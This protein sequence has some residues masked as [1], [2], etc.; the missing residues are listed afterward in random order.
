MNYPDEKLEK[1]VAR[2]I[3]DVAG[4]Q[5]DNGYL[6]TYFT[7][8]KEERFSDLPL[9]HE[10]YCAGHL[11]EAAVAHHLATGKTSLL[12]VATRFA[13]LIC[14][15]FGPDKRQ[16]APGHEEIELALMKLYWLKG[17]KCY[18]DRAKFFIEERGK[19]YAGGDEYR[20][21]QVLFTE[22]KEIVGHAVRAMYLMS[23][24]SDVYRKTND[25]SLM[26]TLERLW[27]NMTQTKMYITGGMGSRYEGE[28]FGK[29]YEL[30]NDR[31]Y[32]ETCAAIGNIFWN[33][34]M[35]QLTGDAKY[36]DV[37]EKTLYNG[38]LSG[39]SLNGK[40]YFYQNPL[41]SDGTH[42]RAAFLAFLSTQF[43][44]K[45][46]LTFTLPASFKEPV[47]ITPSP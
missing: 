26:D 36:A 12:D 2:L 31:A 6:N 42:K 34:R 46:G 20:Q 27:K 40:K 9:K 15:T 41:Q 44:G 18:L 24:A 37:M 17:E 22:Q 16:G 14:R 32:A 1:K 39:I 45:F 35:L 47:K 11:I 23:G 33:Y 30:P 5:E 8:K 3:E 38:F 7:L 13:G 43:F 28:A 4:A 25:K 21:D 19:G 29:N 10:L